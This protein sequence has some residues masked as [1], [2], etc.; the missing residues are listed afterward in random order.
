MVSRGICQ[1][2]LQNLAEFSVES[3]GP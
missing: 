1:T 3:F 2:S